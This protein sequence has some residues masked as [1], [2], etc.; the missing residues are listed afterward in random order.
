M[1]RVLGL[2]GKYELQRLLGQ[3]GLIEVW[4]AFDT[5]SKRSVVLKLLHPDLQIDP[6]FITRFKREVPGISSLGHPNIVKILD[7]QVF[8]PK[9]SDDLK[10]YIIMN[11]VKGKTLADYIRYTS[12]AGQFPSAVD[13]VHLFTAIGGAIDYAHQHG[14]IHAD[15]K[16]SNILLDKQYLLRNL[17]GE[18]KLTDFGIAKMLATSTAKF[19]SQLSTSLYIAPEQALYHPSG[20]ELSDIYSLGVILYEICT[21]KLPFE[22]ESTADIMMDLSSS[23]PPSPASINANISQ[24]ASDVI[25]RSLAKDPAER[26]TSASV[27]MRA[28]AHALDVPIPENLGWF[29]SLSD[30][31]GA[32]PMLHPLSQSEQADLA[33]ST[34][35]L[36][37]MYEPADQKDPWSPPASP[38]ATTAPSSTDLRQSPRSRKPGK[39]QQRAVE[40]PA[41]APKPPRAPRSSKSSSFRSMSIVR[42]QAAEK[43][44]SVLQK[45]WASSSRSIAGKVHNVPMAVDTLKGALFHSRAINIHK[46]HNVPVVDKLKG[47]DKQKIQGKRQKVQRSY[48][49]ACASLL[50]LLCTAGSLFSFAEYHTYNATYQHDMS[51]AR[52]GTQHLQRGLGL[53]ETL[54]QDPLDGA[55]LQK[56][57]HEFTASLM[58]FSQLDSE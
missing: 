29:T 22:D 9:G 28:L 14:V 13:M 24:A 2:I 20:N 12:R 35:S 48:L 11:Y 37:S 4:K 21:G 26:F 56:A 36:E 45:H 51:L 46:V 30:Q 15:I 49:V 17:M 25:L 40:K 23:M 5:Q 42:K 47:E 31:N 18:P 52:E 50:L 10:A 33:T 41:P 8:R 34:A 27:M 16:P 58:I 6:D 38:P 7:Y 1:S 55:T 44:L 54:Q 57:Q 39:S 43:L 32:S 53:F 3:K 19:N